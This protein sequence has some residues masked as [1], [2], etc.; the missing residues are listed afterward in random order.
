MS[1]PGCLAQSRLHRLE[2]IE[3]ELLGNQANAFLGP[4]AMTIQVV[5]K[6]VNVPGSLVNQR[7][8]NSYKR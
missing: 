3:I 2:H 4:F 1:N 8:D 5:A 6:H 7:A